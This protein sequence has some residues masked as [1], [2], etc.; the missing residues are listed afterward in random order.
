VRTGRSS[1]SKAHRQMAQRGSLLALRALL[2]LCI[3]ASCSPHDW[4]STPA[5]APRSG[6]PT[7]AAGAS[8]LSPLRLRG[9]KRSGMYPA[10]QSKR[11]SAER[12]ARSSTPSLAHALSKRRKGGPGAAAASMARAEAEVSLDDGDGGYMYPDLSDYHE[13]GNVAEGLQAGVW[14]DGG[15]AD[16]GDDEDGRGRR[17]GG[18]WER[19][20]GDARG[21]RRAGAA[22]EEEDS[23]EEEKEGEGDGEGEEEEE[24]GTEELREPL[25][26]RRLRPYE[27]ES[28]M[29]E[30]LEAEEDPFDNLKHVR[31]MNF[32]FN[33]DE[34][35][36][37]IKVFFFFVR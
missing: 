16:M 35:T 3:A 25:P 30:P 7:A 15:L 21:E 10:R 1:L 32:S 18:R 9:G 5:R 14:G 17:G 24:G 28:E 29:E 20:G 6:G 8:R 12:E 19:M 27:R 4:F 2:L 36:E 33:V 34:V 37:Q 31:A 13:D 23:W 22:A 11:L 26:Q